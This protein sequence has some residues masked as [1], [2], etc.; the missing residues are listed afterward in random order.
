[1]LDQQTRQEGDR[2]LRFS[3][4]DRAEHWVQMITFTALA[5]TGLIQKWPEGWFSQAAFRA[6]GG[7]E[8]VRL[9]HRG[10]STVL[11]L[12]IVY[13]LYTVGRRVYVERARRTM[14]PSRADLEAI[15]EQ[16]AY[17][18]RR[19]DTPPKQGRFTWD[20]KLEYWAVVWGT[21]IMTITGF[22]LW[23]PIATAQFLPGQ[24]IPAAKAAHSGEALLAV[25]AILVWHIYN[26]HVR[27]FNRSMF[28][29]YLSRE[30]M[31]ERHPI[32]LEEIDAGVKP[33][34]N[35]GQARRQ[36]VFLR[37]YGALAVVLLVGI[38]FFVTFE[39]TAIT[40]IEPPEVV[41]IF[42]RAP[43]PTIPVRPTA[44]P[45]VPT[46]TLP[47]QV[48]TWDATIGPLFAS[49][50]GGCHGE[51]ATAGLDITTYAGALA[52][53]ASGPAVVPGDPDASNVIAVMSEGGHPGQFDEDQLSRISE[54]I[55]EGAPES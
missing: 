20:E 11:L 14:L 40:T 26:V 27:H 9:I 33:P 13:H 52:G 32:E 22:M 4:S 37:A 18:V 31:A 35:G 43:Q 47:D 24:F 12:A 30:E 16:F 54:W 1:M 34:A 50:C 23:N 17:I 53:G 38:Y 46:T 8:A 42:V 39:D 15:R 45:P 25:L 6:L 5:F 55:T 10:F 48:D 28:T 44:P 21:V 3:V 7:V 49:T 51:S 19:R 36:E 41:E 29:G 2:V